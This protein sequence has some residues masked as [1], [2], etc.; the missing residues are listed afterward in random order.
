VEV[1][2]KRIYAFLRHGDEETLLVLI[3]LSGEPISDYSLS[4]AGGPLGE[5][6]AN[7]VFTGVPV[8]AP[9]VNANGG[10]DGYA[11]LAELEAYGT[12]IVQLK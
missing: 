5:G 3:N 8:S 1:E 9:A 2:D 10:F 12:Y 11:P 4:L 7:E 6:S